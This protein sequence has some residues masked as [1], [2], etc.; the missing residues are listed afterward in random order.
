MNIEYEF[1]DYN[2]TNIEDSI[3]FGTIKKGFLISKLDQNLMKN[4]EKIILPEIKNEFEEKLGDY[5]L[6]LFCQQLKFCLGERLQSGV[7]KNGSNLFIG[8]ISREW[9]EAFGSS[10]SGKRFIAIENKNYSDN[11]NVYICYEFKENAEDFFK[12][13][14]KKFGFSLDFEGNFKILRE[15]R[16]KY[17]YICLLYNIQ[18]KNVKASWKQLTEKC[19]NGKYILCN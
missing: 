14:P 18:S 9:F 3:K 13:I 10:Y 16:N 19:Y 1:I 6:T 15:I 5:L 4:A 7:L 11:H 12:E 2:N 8:S 17:S